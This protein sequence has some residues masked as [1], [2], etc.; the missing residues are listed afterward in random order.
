MN[1]TP[2]FIPAIRLMNTPDG[3][4]TFET[5]KLPVLKT[6]STSSFRISNTVE[7]WEKSD[8]PAPRKQ[9][10][11]TVKGK[12]RFKVSS[13]ETFLIEPGIILLAED[14][15]GKGHSWEFEEGETCERLYIPIPD[16]GESFFIPDYK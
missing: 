16:H 14:V 9:Y 13:G 2:E 11:V 4:S 1:E 12:I 5:G 6:I 10:V 15:E 8:H 3:R 7:E